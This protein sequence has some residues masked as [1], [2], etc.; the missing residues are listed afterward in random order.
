MGPIKNI[1]RTQDAISISAPVILPGE[2]FKDVHRLFLTLYGN[3]S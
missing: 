1:V 3:L 2:N